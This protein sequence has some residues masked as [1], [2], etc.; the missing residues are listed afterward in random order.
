M[1]KAQRSVKTEGWTFFDRVV[2]TATLHD[3]S[4]WATEADLLTI[5]RPRPGLPFTTIPVAGANRLVWTTFTPQQID[6]DVECPSDWSYLMGILD[7][8]ERSGV[9]LIRLDAAGYAIKRAGTSCFMIPET[10]A[11]IDRFTAEAHARGPGSS[12]RSTPTT[13]PRSRSP[14]GS[15]GSTASPSRPCCTPSTPANDRA[16]V[17][18][19]RVRP[20]NAI[21]VLDTHDGI[22]VIDVGPDKTRADGGPY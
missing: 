12:S 21:T 11:F 17:E 5:Y 22:G 4:P 14:P 10:F 20:A 15:T 8:L 16:L 7:E 19:L 2:Q 13:A 1:T 3:V 9:G 6:I 18:R